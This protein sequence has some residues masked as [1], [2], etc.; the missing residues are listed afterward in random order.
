MATFLEGVTALSI[1]IE[2][3]MVAIGFKIVFFSSDC[4]SKK[5]A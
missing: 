1:G 4:D 2:F 5:D 3:M